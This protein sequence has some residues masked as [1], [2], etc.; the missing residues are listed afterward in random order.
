MNGNKIVIFKY[1]TY[2]NY[3]MIDARTFSIEFAG[4]GIK[5][6]KI[7]IP[8]AFLLDTY[9]SGVRAQDLSEGG[10]LASEELAYKGLVQCAGE[11]YSLTERGVDE[12]EMKLAEVLRTLEIELCKKRTKPLFDF[13][14]PYKK[15]RLIS[16]PSPYEIKPSIEGTYGDEEQFSRKEL[17]LNRKPQKKSF[18]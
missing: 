13:R 1:F 14:E 7:L 12:Y 3:Y 5:E 17:I 10:V 16:D 15:R 9:K 11:T 4:M 8:N 18:F 2:D 6:G